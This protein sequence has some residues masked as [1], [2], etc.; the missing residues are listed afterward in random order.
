MPDKKK[1]RM[2][3]TV[4]A[5]VVVEGTEEDSVNDIEMVRDLVANV[6][7]ASVGEEGF[8]G[9]DLKMVSVECSV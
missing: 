1:L 5:T 9:D 7:E 6:L 3:Y 4:T 2:T 8:E